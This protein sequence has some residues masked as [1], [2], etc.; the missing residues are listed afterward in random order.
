MPCSGP[1]EVRRCAGEQDAPVV[2][3]HDAVAHR[4]HILDDVRGEQNQTVLRRAGKQV[5]EVDALLRVQTD[6]GLVENQQRRIAQKRLRN[7][8]PLAL[9]AGQ[10]TDFGSDLFF[11][12][13]RLDCLL[14]GG[15]GIC[16]PFERGHIVEK[17][18]D[19]QLVEQAKIL[20][21]IAQPGLELPVCFGKRLPVHQDRAGGRQQRS[22]Q[23][24]HQGG[25]A[26]AVRAEQTDQP[27]RAQV[28]GK[29]VQRLF[30]VWVGHTDVLNVDFHGSQSFLLGFADRIPAA[31]EADLEGICGL[32]GGRDTGEILHNCICGAFSKN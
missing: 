27:G 8:Y 5:A 32:C 7:A 22:H 13:D 6:R 25:L 11:Q 15:P 28:K 9:P 26:R 12:I 17:L 3:D 30:P 31:H 19:G 18:C 10:G 16:D 29:A 21:Q 4:L 20:R 14:D 2:D 1:D 24:L 23:Q